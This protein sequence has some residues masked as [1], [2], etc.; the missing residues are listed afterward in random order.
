MDKAQPRVA[1]QPGLYP[2]DRRKFFHAERERIDE[3]EDSE[4]GSAFVRRWW[5]VER[6]LLTDVLRKRATSA[7][8]RMQPRQFD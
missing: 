5:V 1:C 3:R 6:S 2:S 8:E 7:V 4:T